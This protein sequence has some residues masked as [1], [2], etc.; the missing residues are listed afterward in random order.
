VQFSPFLDTIIVDKGRPQ[1]HGPLCHEFDRH[2]TF[3][4]SLTCASEWICKHP[5]AEAF[6]EANKVVR[7]VV[8]DD[9]PLFDFA[10]NIG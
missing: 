2:P 9:L 1:L 8:R 3:K 6:H 4:V 7:L 10:K 5:T